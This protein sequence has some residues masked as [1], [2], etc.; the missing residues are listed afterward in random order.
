MVFVARDDKGNT[1]LISEARKYCKYYCPECKDD[2]IVKYGEER[3]KHFAHKSNRTCIANFYLK[4][5]PE[6]ESF[7]HKQG[8]EFLKMFVERKHEIKIQ[9]ECSNCFTTK[10]DII[11]V[12]NVRVSI[13]HK[14]EDGKVADMALI[15]PNGEIILLEIL[16]SHK[17]IERKHKWYEIK[18]EDIINSITNKSHVF[19]CSRKDRMCRGECLSMKEIALKLGY[20]AFNPQNSYEELKPLWKPKKIKYEWLTQTKKYIDETTWNTF[21]QRR[22]CII[23]CKYTCISFRRPYCYNCYYKINNDIMNDYIC[24]TPDYIKTYILNKYSFLY[25]IPHSKQT[26]DN[27]QTDKMIVI[28]EDTIHIEKDEITLQ[29]ENST[30]EI[31]NEYEQCIKCNKVF[32]GLFRSSK[33]FFFFGCRKIC[34]ICVNSMAG[35]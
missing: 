2:L 29:G 35:F 20:L 3:S 12:E 18:A 8:K 15:Y 21:E 6:G 27:S 22:R 1:I 28:Y 16:H 19:H 9:K 32:D 13:E 23:C 5:S 34:Y 31:V 24:D 17:T 33:P 26:F 10:E 4:P 25:E 14:L 30:K 7:Y 11:S